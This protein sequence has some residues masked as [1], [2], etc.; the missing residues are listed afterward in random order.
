MSLEIKS[1]GLKIGPEG[2]AS[3]AHRNKAFKNELEH[4]VAERV[5]AGFNFAFDQDP[6]VEDSLRQ[7][8]DRE[9][10]LGQRINRG[11]GMYPLEIKFKGKTVLHLPE[12]TRNTV[13]DSRDIRRGII[14]P[15]V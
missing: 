9:I 2:L 1:I 8:E 5:Q 4:V 13:Y 10:Q 12:V 7:L 3:A 6:E 15:E 11:A 14:H